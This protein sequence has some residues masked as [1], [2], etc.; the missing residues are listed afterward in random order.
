MSHAKT[1]EID[2]PAAS[3]WSAHPLAGIGD[4]FAIKAQVA[5]R[6]AYINQLA[7]ASQNPELL[8]WLRNRV[9]EP[10]GVIS[11]RLDEYKDS[12]IEKNNLQNYSSVE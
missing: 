8:R 4:D 11:K 10:F 1:K 5:E 6:L 3:I 7:N 9:S 12:I 2:T